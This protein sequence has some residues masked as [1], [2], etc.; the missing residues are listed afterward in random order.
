MYSRVDDGMLLKLLMRP[1]AFVSN[2]IVHQV[3]VPGTS[4]RTRS[5]GLRAHTACIVYNDLALRTPN[6]IQVQ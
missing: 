4:T 3:Q 6:Y 1:V 2:T 5:L